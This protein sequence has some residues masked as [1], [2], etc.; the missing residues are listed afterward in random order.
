MTMEQLVKLIAVKQMISSATA[1]KVLGEIIKKELE[2]HITHEEAMLDK[3][4]VERR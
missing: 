2:Q 1:K 4:E 3:I